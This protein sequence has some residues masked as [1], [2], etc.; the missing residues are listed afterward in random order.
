MKTIFSLI[1]FA[2]IVACETP[3]MNQKSEPLTDVYKHHDEVAD[4]L[5]GTYK[6]VSDRGNYAKGIITITKE[7][8]SIDVEGY[9]YNLVLDD[10]STH[11]N[12]KEDCY[13]DIYFADGTVIRIS[14]WVMYNDTIWLEFNGKLIAVLKRE[15]PRIPIN[16]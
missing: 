10:Y 8:I 2:T 1:L 5:V 7:V 11:T 15:L 3:E 16:N 14:D 4:H 12:L 13:F 9:R 6:T